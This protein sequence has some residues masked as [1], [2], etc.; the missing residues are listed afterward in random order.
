GEHG[1]GEHGAGEHGAGEHGAG[2]H[3]AGEHGAGGQ[4]GGEH[5]AGGHGTREHGAGEHGA[6]EHGAGEHGAGE[7]GAGEHRSGEHGLRHHATSFTD[8]LWRGFGRRRFDCWCE[9]VRSDARWRPAAGRRDGRPVRLAV[10]PQELTAGSGTAHAPPSI[11]TVASAPRVV[12]HVS[13]ELCL[14]GRQ[15]GRST[16]RRAALPD[17]MDHGLPSAVN[18]DTHP[19]SWTSWMRPMVLTAVTV[20]YTSRTSAPAFTPSWPASTVNVC[21]PIIGASSR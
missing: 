19:H 20:P 14:V 13:G 17:P 8:S 10:C 18:G 11:T 9:P 15:E 3:G 5:G 6:G 12:V 7:H 1:A 2:E 16:T 21:G 4:G